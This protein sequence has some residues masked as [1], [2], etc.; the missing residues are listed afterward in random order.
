MK[1]VNLI[2]YCILSNLTSRTR[3]LKTCR[4][5]PKMSPKPR[6]HD[7]LQRARSY[8]DVTIIIPI[9][10]MSTAAK[11]N[12]LISGCQRFD[13]PIWGCQGSQTST[14]AT[15]F[16]TVRKSVVFC[17]LIA[18][19][20]FRATK[21]KATTSFISYHVIMSTHNSQPKIFAATL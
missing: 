10:G 13:I 8:G 4:N 12:I 2:F 11:G 3:A 5:G 6:F 15:M 17:L 1:L 18:E 9:F 7:I 14:Q 16:W 19:K 21:F 20:T